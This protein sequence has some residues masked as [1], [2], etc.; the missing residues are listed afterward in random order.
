MSFERIIRWQCSICETK[1]EKT[2]YGFPK[3]WTFF[4][5]IHDSPHAPIKH[6]CEICLPLFAKH[7]SNKAE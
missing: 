4:Y 3:G 6:T 2:D 7:F 1:A 5:W